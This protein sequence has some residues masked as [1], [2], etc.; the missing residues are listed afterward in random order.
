VTWLE[1][2]AAR[3]PW[4]LGLR[5]GLEARSQRHLGPCPACLQD[6]RSRSDGRRGAVFLVGKAGWKCGACGVGGGSVQLAAYRILGK[7]PAKGDPLWRELRADL[8]SRGLCSPREGETLPQARVLPRIEPAG[9]A[10]PPRPR[11]EEVAHVWGLCRPVTEDPGVANWLASRGLDSARIER[12]DLARALPPDVG[13]LP[14]WAGVWTRGAGWVPWSAGWRCLVPAYDARGVH[15]SFRARWIDGSPPGTAPKTAAA[16]AGERSSC[17]LVLAD[18][19][20]VE[21]LRTGRPPIWWPPD[22]PLR[23]VVVEGEPDWLTWATLTAQEYTDQNFA[24]VIGVWNGA[25]TEAFVARIPFGSSVV[26]R[27]HD[28]RDGERYRARIAET[29]RGRCRVFGAVF[30]RGGV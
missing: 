17:G 2:I 19:P 12:L 27:T 21:I 25:W 9:D 20:A 5:L 7:V 30:D 29:L 13:E 22:L 3:G 23:V 18:R 4:D 10:D 14:K 6:R 1:E 24:G 8:A 28:D 15:V 11:V 26:I 16:A